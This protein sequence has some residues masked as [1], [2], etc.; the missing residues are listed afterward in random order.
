MSVTNKRNP[1]LNTYKLNNEALTCENMIKYLGVT[2]DNKLTFGQHIQEKCKNAT[3]ILNILR[4][5][6]Y[7]APRT[8]KSKAYKSCVL[9]ILEYASSCWSP[10]SQKLSNTLEMVQHNAAKFIANTY[11]KKGDFKQFSISKILR[12]LNLDTLEERRTQAKLIMAYKIINE[13][14]ILDPITLPK[15]NSQRPL[16]QCNVPKVGFENQLSEPEPGLQVVNNTFFYSVPKLWND[17]VTP[18][19]ANAPSVEAFKGHFNKNH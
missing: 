14:V 9:P 10:S 6:L 1:I 15:S 17:N 8:V 18:I 16:R 4:R 13:H 19:Q 5:N 2:I 12:N 11:N 7:F 3:T